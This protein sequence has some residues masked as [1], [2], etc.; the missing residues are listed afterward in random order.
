[1]TYRGAVSSGAMAVRKVSL[2]TLV[3]ALG[4]TALAG[5]GCY[6]P[7]VV[8]GKLLCGP[9][10]ACPDDFSCVDGR[11]WRGGVMT[12]DSGSTDDG[13]PPLDLAC[14]L[15]R[16]TPSAPVAG[17]CDPACQSGCACGEKCTIDSTGAAA[18]VKVTDLKQPFEACDI[19]VVAGSTI[20]RDNC[21]AGSICLN[22]DPISTASA[23]CF[24][25]CASDNDCAAINSSCVHRPIGS[26]AAGAPVA[27]VC[28]VPFAVCD[29]IM[30]TGCT[31]SKKFC[32]LASPDLAG[33]SRTVCDFTTGSSGPGESCGWSRDCFPGLVCPPGVGRCVA[34]CIN[35]SNT[36]TVGTC[37]PYG[38]TYGYC[39]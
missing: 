13:P 20:R 17:A 28:D 19:E 14:Q 5:A 9:S 3:A 27:Q 2:G 1:M 31:G 12:V 24:A 6:S 26:T 35:G 32:Y 39:N 10:N 16:C 4:A 11:C 15:P 30:N 38:A 18:C 21:A 8:D 29:P 37:Q 36:C 25:L 33:N 34:P 23:W 22:P 7:S